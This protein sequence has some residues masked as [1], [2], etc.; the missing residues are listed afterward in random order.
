MNSEFA[1]EDISSQ[2]VEKY[3]YKFLREEA[4]EPGTCFVIE[5]YPVDKYSGYKRQIAWIDTEEYRMWKTEFYN[6][7]DSLLK[8]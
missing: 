4:C 1:Y 5:Q 2:E 6:R 8:T 3:T 7:R